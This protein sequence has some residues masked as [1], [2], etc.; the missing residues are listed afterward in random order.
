MEESTQGTNHN[1]VAVGEE[2]EEEEEERVGHMHWCGC[3][4]C[5]PMLKGRVFAVR[6][7]TSYQQLSRVNL[8]KRKMHIISLTTGY[9][10]TDLSCIIAHLNFEA[11]CLSPDVLWAALISLHHRWSAGLPRRD[12]VTNRL[13]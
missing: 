8:K 6:N 11:V 1:L 3:G 12:G 10:F 9:L 2:E 13:V 4:N 7:S 5:V